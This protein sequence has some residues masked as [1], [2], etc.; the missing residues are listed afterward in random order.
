[1]DGWL[2]M[3]GRQGYMGLHDKWSSDAKAKADDVIGG[4]GHSVLSQ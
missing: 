2:A 3:G 4:G 1:M